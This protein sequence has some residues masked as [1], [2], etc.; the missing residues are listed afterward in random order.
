MNQIRLYGPD[1]NP[2]P[3]A[4]SY[5]HQLANTF[6]KEALRARYDAAQT[7]VNNEVHWQM[8]DH[9]DPH[10]A[11]SLEVRRKLRSRS[12]YEVI[13]N[14][15]YLK[16]TLLTI[17]NDFIGSGPKLQITDRRI[18]TERRRL[19]EKRWNT[20][21]RAI[22]LRRKLWRSRMAKVVD[23]ETFFR[24]YTNTGS[25]D[26]VKLD[27]QVLE[28][29]M[30]SSEELTAR[31]KR[32][33]DNLFE[34]DGVRF[35]RFENALA[36]HVLN[37][38]PGG[39][40]FFRWAPAM[41]GGNWVRSEFIIHW[42]R[43]DRGWLR[44]IPETTPSLPLCSI[45]RRY[46]MAVLRH[47]EF[48]ADFT[49]ILE[50]EGPPDVRVWTDGAGNLTED[51]PF[52]IF[53]VEMGMFTTMPWGYKM[54][55]LDAVP[56]GV[57]FDEFVGAMLREITRPLLAPF[58]IAAGTSKDSNMASGVLDAS[59]YKGGQLAERH[60]IET[61][62]LDRILHLWWMEGSRLP[63][64]FDESTIMESDFLLANP[65]LREE[66]PEHRWR[67]DPIG[68]DHTDPAKV[69]QALQI[70]HDKGF[71]TDR[72]IQE[73]RYNRDVEDWKEDIRDQ[74]EFRKEV[75]LSQEAA[76]PPGQEAPEGQ[77]EPSDDP[78]PSDQN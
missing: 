52:D 48:A 13:E 22:K 18:S 71:L 64:Y 31:L 16:G 60:D 53:P 67:W 2:L 38:H 19:I 39:S 7:S 63:E 65:T 78:G 23:G 11:N 68:I 21:T 73:T 49:G 50:T 30:V 20:W 25:R 54:K 3:R 27:F 47:K 34:I 74:E 35:D 6:R 33:D 62:V 51:N 24:A 69:A 26:R 70:A 10:S 5:R 46:T 72:D 12:R 57:Q 28:C 1:G 56:D 59:I 45:L 29:D 9:L 61:E 77:E 66:P 40:A 58:N 36:Y 43:Q 75:G 4:S 8:A 14:N 37:Y 44:G 32:T 55:Q 15:P 41:I 76:P 17:S 42:F